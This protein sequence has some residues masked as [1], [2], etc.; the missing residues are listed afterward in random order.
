MRIVAVSDT[1]GMLNQANFPG[2]DVL[3][4]AGDILPNYSRDPI[5]DAF[6]QEKALRELDGFVKTLPFKHTIF[7]AGNH[8][9]LAERNRSALKTIKNMIYLEDAEVVLDGFKFY[10]SPW[11][12]EFCNWAFNLPRK[13]V[14]LRR[15]WD[16]I[17]E[18]VDVLI[19]H[20]PPYGILDKIDPVGGA[21]ASRD[22]EPLGCELLKERLDHLNPKLHVFGHIHGSYGQTRVGDTIFMNASLCNEGYQPINPPQ[23]VEIFK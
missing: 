22:I 13:G 14:K 2:G 12:P 23:M 20:S 5:K 15:L 1:H 8:D 17:P 16:N 10:G 21:W 6:Q 19:T 3:V 7:V 18:D 9:W 11:Q 4:L